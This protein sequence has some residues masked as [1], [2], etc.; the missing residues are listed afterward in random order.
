MKSLPEPPNE[1]IKGEVLAGSIMP[2]MLQKLFCSPNENLLNIRTHALIK[3]S[4]PCSPSIASSLKVPEGSH[5]CSAMNFASEEGPKLSV[6][7]IPG[8][9]I[10]SPPGSELL[11]KVR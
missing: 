11:F 4:H 9:T 6:V 3:Q 8:V 1:L 2:H 10:M 7:K 5:S